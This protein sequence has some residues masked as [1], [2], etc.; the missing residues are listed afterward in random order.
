MNFISKVF[1]K[2]LA[3]TS[4]VALLGGASWLLFNGYLVHVMAQRNPVSDIAEAANRVA[5]DPFA[6]GPSLGNILVVS[7]ASIGLL[8]LLVVIAL[9]VYV[10][11][12][13][14]RYQHYSQRRQQRPY[15]RPLAY[16]QIATKQRGVGDALNA[17]VQLEIA[18][19]LRGMHID[20]EGQ[21]PAI[22]PPE[23]PLV[24]QPWE[25]EPVDELLRDM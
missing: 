22:M 4:L 8:T 9:T 20:Q 5:T 12:F 17:L 23:Q 3:I 2:V 6:K 10:V 19:Y 16:A 25:T 13:R 24:V 21:S 14:R 7:L 15:R 18:R 1:S 11:R